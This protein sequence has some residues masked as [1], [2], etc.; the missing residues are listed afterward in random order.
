[1]PF[2]VPLSP[3]ANLLFAVVVLLEV[4]RLTKDA[5]QAL[6]RTMEKYVATCRLVLV[7]ENVSKV[8]SAW[9]VY[10]NDADCPGVG[11]RAAPLSVPE[12]P[13]A[14]TYL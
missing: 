5:Q 13:G 12:R 2:V 10:G 11:H 8:R 14:G 3:S 4:D 1:M 6:R 7:A 9:F